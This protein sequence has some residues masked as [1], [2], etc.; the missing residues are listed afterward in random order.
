MIAEK[1]MFNSPTFGQLSFDSVL[2]HIDN[3]IR[4]SPEDKYKVIVG[5]DS[6]NRSKTKIVIVICICRVGKGGRYFYSVEI[7][8]KVKDL[9]TKIYQETKL[10]LDIAKAV[11]EHMFKNNADYDFCIHADIGR[12]GDTSKLINEIVGWIEAEG[13]QCHI[14][15]NSFVASTIADR[16]S[17]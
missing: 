7:I 14:K 13:F 10:S 3:Y 12:Y 2:E 4:E 5:T 17:K 9:R 6:Q 11:N 1:I 8:P 16:I 15:P